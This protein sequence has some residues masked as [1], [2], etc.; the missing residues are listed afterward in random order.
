MHMIRKDSP[1]FRQFGEVY[2]SQIHS[3]AVKAWRRHKQMTQ[4]FAVPRGKIKLVIYDDR[5][6]SSTRGNLDILD[7]GEDNYILIK[8][9]VM[10]W[11]GFKGISSESSLIVNCADLVHDPSEIERKDAHDP[12]I[13]YLWNK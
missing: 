10:L 5:P 7:T 6:E 8:I 11:Y 9:P 1:E 12:S 2:F 3:G 4:L 13:P